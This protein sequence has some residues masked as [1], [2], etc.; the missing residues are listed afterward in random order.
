MNSETIQ[1][2]IEQCKRCI[3]AQHVIADS[4]GLA[5]Y[6]ANISGIERQVPL[7]LRPASTDEVKRLVDLANES[8]LPLYP[9]S[10]GNN[11]GLGSRLPAQDGSAVLDLS[12]MNRIIEVNVPQH[13]AVVEPGVTQQQLYEHITSGGLPLVINI[14]GAGLQT[15]LIGNALE[16]GI[17]YFAGRADE[18][19]ALEVVLGTGEI[20]QTGH[21]HYSG[22]KTANLY[23][24]GTGPSLDGL[25]AQS[26]FGVVTRATVSLM[27]AP[28]CR[29]A[30]IAKI[31]DPEGLGPLIDAI[32]GLSND[33]IIRGIVHIG[34][35]HRSQITLAPLL[36]AH[37]SRMHGGEP[38]S[39]KEHAERILE[40]E[41]FGCWTALIGLSGTTEMVRSASRE[42]RR[43]L[44]RLAAVS[45]LDDR[46]L[47]RARALLNGLSPF[48]SIARDKAAAL[49]AMEP[50][51]A[52]TKGI[53]TDAP[54]HSLYWPLGLWPSA[55]PPEPD[56]DGCGMLYCLPFFSFDGQTACSVAKS[57]E[58]IFQEHGFT[59]YM[60]LNT[61]DSKTLE[62]VV[63]LAF[64]K[65]DAQ[66]T[67]AA[68]RCIEELQAYYIETGC[69]PYRVGIQTMHQV[70]DADDPFWQKIRDLKQ[71]FDPNHI[72]A[73]G[74]YNLV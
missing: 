54:L 58:R 12:R 57:A 42:I 46:R 29:A 59:P 50:L 10:R 34:N 68:H 55:D 47:A 69:I 43:R 16:R 24:H 20:I 22:S 32:G 9:I 17:G 63:N 51:F 7:V 74:R 38:A 36:C 19:C 61:I 65:S 8:G 72:I 66:Q 52:M 49:S 11:W 73:P 39:H 4:S 62:C 2:V 41:N 53:P 28:P 14:T 56:T 48:S 33:Q 21:A 30:I 18:L 44:G 64:S 40:Q 31:S 71:V 60:T 25:F 1:P 23:R 15:S 45:L 3:G 27:P 70:V 37:L 35:Q 67:E 5:D 6:S 13:Y 26:N